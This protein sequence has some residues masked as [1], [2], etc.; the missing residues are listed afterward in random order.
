MYKYFIFLITYSF[1]N[2][3]IYDASPSLNCTTTL[4]IMSKLA[5]TFPLT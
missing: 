1:F 4:A 5:A 3:E 2:R